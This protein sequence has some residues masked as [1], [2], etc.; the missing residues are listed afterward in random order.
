MIYKIENNKIL[1]T[2]VGINDSSRNLICIFTKEQFETN[3]FSLPIINE[4]I[5]FCKIEDLKKYSYGTLCIPKKNNYP[6]NDLLQFY[7]INENIVFIDNNNYVVEIINNIIQTKR[8]IDYNIFKFFHDFL[9]MIIKDD[10]IYLEKLENNLAN[11]EDKILVSDQN[12]FSKK[13]I[14]CKKEILRYYHYYGQLLDM[15]DTL[16]EKYTD[17]KQIFKTLS[18]KI[19]RLQSETLLLR[20]Y[21]HQLQDLYESQISLHQNNVMKVLTIV[22]T[23]FLPLTLITGWYGMNFKYMPDI[24]W[25]M[26]YP[27][28]IIIFGVIIAAFIICLIIFKKKKFW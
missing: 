23:I 22:T 16:V 10:L 15:I 5:H 2:T 17:M 12:D 13:I 24:Y 11:L 27:L 14:V 6:K 18:E 28:M 25:K 1:E 9:E 4:H 3:E 21:T 8:K 26:G 20:E 7:I 19:N